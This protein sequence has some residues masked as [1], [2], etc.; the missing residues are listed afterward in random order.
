[1]KPIT[2][3]AVAVSVLV[4]CFTSALVVCAVTPA[5]EVVTVEHFIETISL[6]KP[7][8]L[9][10][11][12]APQSA[13]VASFAAVEFFGFMFAENNPETGNRL[14]CISKS[15]RSRNNPEANLAFAIGDYATYEKCCK[16]LDKLVIVWGVPCDSGGHVVV[17]VQDVRK[18]N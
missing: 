18:I 7:E 3:I 10:T 2:L 11:E 1:M 6:P 15:E 12:P 9:T 14:L 4:P 5:P 8:A 16:N 13:R 17:L